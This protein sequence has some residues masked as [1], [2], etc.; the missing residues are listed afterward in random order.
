MNLAEFKAYQERRGL[1]SRTIESNI[2]LINLLPSECIH[3]K[4]A[5]D[6]FIS[7]KLRDGR[8]P[9]YLNRIIVAMRLY[10]K[11]SGLEWTD[12]IDKVRNTQETEKDILYED[13]LRDF[14]H[15]QEWNGNPSYKRHHEAMQLFWEIV[16]YTGRRLSEVASLE[17][18]MIRWDQKVFYLGRTKTGRSRVIPIYEPF[19]QHLKDYLKNHEYELLFPS[20][21]NKT[22]PI[23]HHTWGKSFRKRLEM[24]GVEKLPNLTAYSIRHSVITDTVSPLGAGVPVI[25]AMN[26]F[27]HTDPKVTARYIHYDTRVLHH[28][29]RRIPLA[30]EFLNPVEFFKNLQK[31]LEN[32]IAPLKADPNDVRFD[33]DDDE[34]NIYFTFKIRVKKKPNE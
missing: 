8:K 11:Y 3:N 10:G 7:D 18:G 25:D 17:K 19:E 14:L 30:R 15:V 21:Q 22:K 24:I 13:R 34:E 9:N 16:M 29:V 27:G 31:W 5:F 20:R 33:L 12:S 23:N 32:F 1:A 2:G 26:L 4:K 6:K 28:T